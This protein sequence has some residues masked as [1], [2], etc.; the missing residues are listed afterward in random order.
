MRTCW[1]LGG[2]LSL[3]AVTPVRAGLYLPAEP[4]PW[5]LPSNPAQFRQIH[6]E[7]LS[8]SSVDANV[9]KRDFPTHVREQIAKLE[10]QLRAGKLSVEDSI[11]LSGYYLLQAQREALDKAINLLTPVL[12]REPK[13]FMVLANLANA[14]QGIGESGR[15]AEFQRQVLSNWPSTHAGWKWEQ[16]W[17]Y[18]RSEKYYLTLLEL[19]TRE[20]LLNQSATSLDNLFPGVPFADENAKYLI[21][22]TTYKARDKLP[23]D[24]LALVEQMLLWMPQDK[25]LLWMFAE[26]LNARGDVA[27]TWGIFK[28][29]TEGG[30]N[31]GLFRKHRNAF[32][33]VADT[34]P[35]FKKP[36]VEVGGGRAIFPGGSTAGDTGQQPWLPDWRQ[37]GVGFGSGL[38]VGM[39]L[40]L[41][42]RQFRRRR[43]AGAHASSSPGDGP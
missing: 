25:R 9:R 20:K 40:L 1:L 7:L 39:L 27:L 17:W 12:Q 8:V 11:N 24:V 3:L 4:D 10:R 32:R 6:G 35:R 42:F 34:D 29:L 15:A 19:R 2:L 5:P 31:N 41:Q 26:L 23:P 36:K 38:L 21:G 37:L 13:N 22:E 18:R 43:L 33:D 30:Y 28:E 16:L 14:Y